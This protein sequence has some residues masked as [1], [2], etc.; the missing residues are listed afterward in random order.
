MCTHAPVTGSHYYL[1]HVLL[2]CSNIDPSWIIHACFQTLTGGVGCLQGAGSPSGGAIT[3]DNDSMRHQSS[4]SE[5]APE[6]AR[7]AGECTTVGHADIS[8]EGVTTSTSS[9]AE[10]PSLPPLSKS[11]QALVGVGLVAYGGL[12]AATATVMVGVAAI[13]MLPQPSIPRPRIP[14]FSLW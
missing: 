7:A 9:H 8:Q 5:A 2:L 14:S 3:T 13:K 10:S 12:F 4:S 1:L 11:Q 6:A